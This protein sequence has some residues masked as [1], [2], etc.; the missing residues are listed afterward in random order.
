MRP[1]ATRTILLLA[2]ALALGACS[3]ERDDADEA[4][5]LVSVNGSGEVSAAPDRAT[6]RLG[7]DARSKQ[8]PAAQRQADE[9]VVK[10]MAVA[11]KLG[12]AREQVQTTAIQIQ[13]EFQWSND[14]RRT[15]LGYLVQR[16]VTV[17]VRDL[18]KLGDLMEQ[19]LATGVNDVG[20]PA[21]SSS[22]EKALYRGAIRAAAEDAR[23]NAEAL[24]DSLGAGLG[25]L[26]GASGSADGGSPGPQPMMMAAMDGARMK[27]EVAQTYEAGQIKFTATVS[28]QFEIE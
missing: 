19:A 11:D 3:L 22:K 5:R 26:Y 13:P 14:G 7:I 18:A 24:A 2:L 15:L 4:P 9:V 28:A 17:E 25:E 20:P 21:L 8:L 1:F 6:V 10:V 23:L 27:T 16:Q 12:I